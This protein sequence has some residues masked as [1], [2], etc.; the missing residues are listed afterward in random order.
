[1]NAMIQRLDSG[2]GFALSFVRFITGLM[3]GWHGY[4]KFADG[5]EG[6][7]GFISFLE[8]PAPAALAFVVAAL[9][10]VG[11]ILLALG[12]LTRPVSLLFIIHF[13]LIFVVVKLVKLDSVMLVGG[14]Q[15][16]VELDLL[17]LG[18]AAL[19]FTHGPGPI[20]ADRMLGLD[21]Q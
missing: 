12:L 3:L 13:A 15:P 2:R 4:R 11:G 14:E 19:F 5:L 16:G 7:E 9:E 21:S 10:L 6:F 18:L 17:Y 1:M 20:G 8:L